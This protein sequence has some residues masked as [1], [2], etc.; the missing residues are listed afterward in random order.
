MVVCVSDRLSAMQTHRT[1][2]QVVFGPFNVPFIES[3]NIIDAN[4][5]NGRE[6]CATYQ[7]I[8]EMLC[9]DNYMT[10]DEDIEEYNNIKRSGIHTFLSFLSLFP[11]NDTE[12]GFFTHIQ[13]KIG[14]IVNSVG[15]LIVSLRTEDLRIWYKI[16]EPTI[17]LDES[18][19]EKF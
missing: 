3:F 17:S 11:Y 9:D 10:K 12:R 7:E 6:N 5:H 15:A 19:L 14:M 2:V 1:Q 8:Y 18:F 16:F 13:K 4:K